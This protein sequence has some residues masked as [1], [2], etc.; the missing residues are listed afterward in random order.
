M[1]PQQTTEPSSDPPSSTSF[2][3]NS[4]LTSVAD[5]EI[6]N[7][8]PDMPAADK[9]PSL[10]I[11]E[12]MKNLK[13]IDG[14]KGEREKLQSRTSAWLSQQPKQPLSRNIDEHE[15]LHD[16]DEESR[17]E[18]SIAPWFAVKP[19]NAPVRHASDLESEG[20]ISQQT[21][22][23]S[24]GRLDVTRKSRHTDIIKPSRQV[25]NKVT[26]DVDNDPENT[27]DVDI[28][29]EPAEDVTDFQ[30]SKSVE[31]IG[32]RSRPLLCRSQERSK[33]TALEDVGKIKTIEEKQAKSKQLKSKQKQQFKDNDKIKPEVQPQQE[34]VMKSGKVSKI[35]KI[36][37]KRSKTS[38][39]SK[40]EPNDLREEAKTV[41]LN[42]I[43]EEIDQLR[44]EADCQEMKIVLSSDGNELVSVLS[45]D[46]KRSASKVSNYIDEL[47]SRISMT[48]TVTKG[49]M[50]QMTDVTLPVA[51]DM[52]SE[53]EMENSK[54][55]QSKFLNKDI[56]QDDIGEEKQA[57]LVDADATHLLTD[58]EK[59]RDRS[60]LSGSTWSRSMLASRPGFETGRV[61]TL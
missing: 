9:Q 60:R 50:T 7:I 10:K 41:P 24:E 33:S 26:T 43:K 23:K 5:A 42:I 8:A 61:F 54:G 28:C 46:K 56:Q 6:S 30:R 12:N 21:V 53:S 4:R 25:L 16:S 1:K 49:K 57:E 22:H 36:Q 35:N 55:E 39:A 59:V 13:P 37:K 27:S 52:D 51:K 40:P 14:L 18:G 34:S 48:G 15:E 20:Q 11:N 31:V 32:R 58:E 3:P 45:S 38:L 19:K 47:D 44:D 2:D 29:V 17:I